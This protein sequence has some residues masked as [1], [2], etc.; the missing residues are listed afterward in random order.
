VY[1]FGVYE[2]VK[3]TVFFLVK[4]APRKRQQSKAAEG[5]SEEW[6]EGRGQA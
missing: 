1:Y 6:A 2:K 5:N 4:G 3:E